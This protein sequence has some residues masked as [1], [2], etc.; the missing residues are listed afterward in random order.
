M[1]YNILKHLAQLANKSNSCGIYSQSPLLTSLSHKILKHL[2]QLANKSNNCGICSREALFK[3]FAAK[4]FQV[5]GL[6]LF[7]HCKYSLTLAF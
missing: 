1:S 6:A 4:D 5:F 2:A 3:A 7:K